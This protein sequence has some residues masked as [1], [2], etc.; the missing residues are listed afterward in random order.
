[1]TVR[2]LYIY[3]TYFKIPQEIV[4]PVTLKISEEIEEIDAT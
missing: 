4:F 3:T 2:E 1:M